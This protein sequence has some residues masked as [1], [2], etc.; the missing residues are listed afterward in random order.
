MLLFKRVSDLQ[1]YLQFIHS[2]NRKLGLV[3][4]MGALHDGHLSL[5]RQSKA[6][7]NVTICT[8]FVNPTQFNESTDLK[9][10]PRTPSKDIKLLL[11][12]GCD[13]LFMPTTEE[14]YPPKLNIRSNYIFGDLEK[15][16]EGAFRPGHFAGVAQVVGRLLDITNPDHLYMGQKDFQQV[17]IVREMIQQR[18]DK[19][20][21]VMCPIIREGDGLAMSS[22]NILLQPEIRKKAAIIFNTLQKAK[23]LIKDK[24][25]LEI[26]TIAL[27][28]LSTPGFQPEY[29]EIADGNTLQPI[30]SFEQT[31]Y[32]VACTAVWAGKVRLIDNTILVGRS[33]N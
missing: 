3:P 11:E 19:L 21:V 20:Q 12:V 5:I 18:P 32:A 28:A 24:S 10:Y 7:S 27:Q 26:K 33:K 8:I 13:V 30:D 22:R 4:T 14:I 16:M 9:K 25:P 29:F 15:V 1:W 17:A 6:K 31:D 2:S 23:S